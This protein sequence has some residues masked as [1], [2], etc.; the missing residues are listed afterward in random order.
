MPASIIFTGDFGCE[1]GIFANFTSVEKLFATERVM[2][3][4]L[5]ATPSVF[6]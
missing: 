5:F 2:H 3:I 6:P 1:H 4:C